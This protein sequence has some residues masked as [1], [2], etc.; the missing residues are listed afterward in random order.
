[1]LALDYLLAQ[2]LTPAA[3]NTQLRALNAQYQPLV[4]YVPVPQVDANTGVVNMWTKAWSD[5][6]RPSIGYEVGF[7]REG[8]AEI[9]LQGKN[10]DE[11]PVWI[12]YVSAGEEELVAR[13]QCE[14][15]WEAIRMVLDIPTAVGLEGQQ[16]VGV[17]P[18]RGIVKIGPSVQV[19]L[20]T[21]DVASAGRVL[22]FRSR[23]LMTLDTVRP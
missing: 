9:V 3:V 21:V 11:I 12:T 8:A 19:E 22:G 16:L 2:V 18:V 14:V 7:S 1:M 13:R 10:R 4:G 15:T 23:W 17:T 5:M 20:V 6:V